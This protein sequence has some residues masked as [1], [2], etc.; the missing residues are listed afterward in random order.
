MQ[1]LKRTN[2]KMCDGM[3]VDERESEREIDGV[4]I[5]PTSRAA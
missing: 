4:R 1:C 5:V 2:Q 3:G